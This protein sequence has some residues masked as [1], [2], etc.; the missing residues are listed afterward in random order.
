VNNSKLGEV[1]VFN[2]ALTISF[3]VVTLLT[4]PRPLIS[5]HSVASSLQAKQIDDQISVNATTVCTSRNL[6][7][8][9]PCMQYKS[10]PQT[11]LNGYNITEFY[12]Y[13]ASSAYLDHMQKLQNW[14][15]ELTSANSLTPLALPTNE[16]YRTTHW[17]WFADFSVYNQYKQSID[18][19][20]NWPETS[21]NQLSEWLAVTLPAGS[22]DGGRH[23]LYVYSDTTGCCGAFSSG[24]NIGFQVEAFNG[25]PDWPWVVIPHEMTNCFTGTA[26]VPNGG[27]PPD[28]W[29][30]GRSP[31]PAMAAVN[32]E[33][34]DEQAYGVSYWQQHDQDD[35]SGSMGTIY[36]MFRDQ[37]QSN[38]GWSLF[39]NAFAAMRNDGL[40][41][42][43]PTY[44]ADSEYLSPNWYQLHY[45][46]SH[47]IAYYLSRATGVDLSSTLNQGSVG[48]MPS[49]W[50][51]T[52]YAYQISLSSVIPSDQIQ[53]P[54]G[55][56]H[57]VI[58]LTATASDPDWGIK[59]VTFWYSIDDSTFYL[60]GKG[61]NTAGNTW[62]I[63]WDTTKTFP[64]KQNTVWVMSVSHDQSNFESP[65]S[66][67]QVFSVDNTPSIDVGDVV[68][69][70]GSSGVWFVRH[71]D[72]SSWQVQWGLSGDVPLLGDVDGDEVKDLIVFRSGT[73]YILKS[74]A[75]YAGWNT[76]SSWMSVQWGLPGDKPLVADFDG[77]G[78]VDLV[79]WR[80]SSGM[81]MF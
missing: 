17:I 20:L 22:F 81:C 11:T 27:W 55:M 67:S 2:K 62:S 77:D 1:Q 63:Q 45:L 23:A 60:L 66:V 50:S 44:T 79:V 48:Q 29:S 37:L 24:S 9:L 80:P 31:F 19:M 49:G 69:W 51:G 13:N 70:R 25:I 46:K 39:Q 42:D 14:K 7:A 5:Y 75:G 52:F 16:I 38:Y 18:P 28:W 65:L 56:R 26:V 71:Q 36:K 59:D 78:K 72:G 34:A 64:S 73:W 57:G 32:V 76:P 15:G 47:V 8:I 21:Y 6:S 33:K 35:A 40:R 61:T 12:V 54:S 53:S 30:D 74:S 43:T 58:Q 10:Y 3:L 68:V 41:L 4:F